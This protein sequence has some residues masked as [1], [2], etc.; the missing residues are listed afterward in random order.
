MQL[1][2]DIVDLKVDSGI[3]PRFV[4]R[5]LHPE[6][7]ERYPGIE[8]DELLVWSLWAA[9]E[10]AFKAFRQAN[11]RYF[12]PN[13]WNVDLKA[14]RVQFETQ[15]WNLEINRSEDA[16]WAMSISAS[17]QALSSYTIVSEM[18]SGTEELSPKEQGEQGRAILHDL[19]KR[20][21]LDAVLQKDEHQIPRLLYKDQVLPYSM[22]HHGRHVFVCLAV[23]HLH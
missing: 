22:S 11:M 23:P 1:G 6:E 21:D 10:S 12:L 3:R 5:I 15:S 8:D 19:L 13:R 7:R 14:S 17:P 16:V 4:E 20:H 9:K 18:R 2:N